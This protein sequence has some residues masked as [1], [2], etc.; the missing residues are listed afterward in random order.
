[1]TDYFTYFVYILA[2]APRGTLYIGITN[3]ILRRMWEHQNETDPTSFT[4]KY[5]VK[6]LVYVEQHNNVMTAILREKR[7]KKWRRTWKFQLIT[8]SN[9][10]WHDLST[11]WQHVA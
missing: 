9:P 2:S 6:H 5:N 4:T 7:L 8:Q 1:M 11:K 3:N 10:H